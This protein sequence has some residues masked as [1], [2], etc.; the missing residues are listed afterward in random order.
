MT[1]SAG[2]AGGSGAAG[3]AGSNGTDGSGGEGAAAV[4]GSG[5]TTVINDGTLSGGWSADGLR[6][7]NAVEFT[8]G[9]N[10]LELHSNS[11]IE[12][13]AVAVQD[14]ES[15]EDTLALG[16][17][18]DGTFDVGLIGTQYIG[19]TQ[20]DKT[21]ISTW[22]VDGQTTEVAPWTVKE[23]TLILGSTAESDTS[24][25]GDMS[26]DLEGT[27]SG[28]GTVGGN[29]TN[30][31]TISPGA[32]T[33]S[34]GTLT[35]EGDYTQSSDGILE[36]DADQTTGLADKIDV[37][38]TAALDG[39]VHV[40]AQSDTAWYSEHVIVEADEGVT[41]TFD[42]VTDNLTNIDT[43]IT[44]NPNTAVIGL[45]RNDVVFQEEVADL[46]DNQDSTA[47]AID[48]L[49]EGSIYKAIVKDGEGNAAHN[50]DLLSGEI[51]A[52]TASA[53]LTTERVSRGIMSDNMRNRVRDS[54]DQ[55]SSASST[56]A[57][58]YT[59][60]KSPIPDAV[61]SKEPYQSHF[62][63]WGEVVADDLTLK[64]DGNAGKTEQDLAGVFVGGNVMLGG[65]WQAGAAYGHTEAE[66]DVRDRD[67][68][69]DIE[70]NTLGLTVGKSFETGNDNAINFLLGGTYTRSGVE[71]KRDVEIGAIQETLASEYD[72]D[73]VQ[74]FT[75][76][77]Y[78]MRLRNRSILEPYVGL[79]WRSL[80]GDDYQEK[81]GTTALSGEGFELDQIN[82]TVGIRFRQGFDIGSLPAWVQ[83]GAGWEHSFGDTEGVAVHRFDG[84]NEFRVTGA[85]LD[86]DAGILDLS[87]GVHLT[88][89]LSLSTSYIGRFSENNRENTYRLGLNWKF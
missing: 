43:S 72:V 83:V 15:Q 19:F 69:A 58:T 39:S 45:M 17:D 10:L 68:S 30:G 9:G 53:L 16:G 52:D 47:G 88:E 51:H 61:V 38:G 80:S 32:G 75:E 62:A 46:T 18:A 65:G 74:L 87:F 55:G 31:G 50:F 85:P 56:P 60:S 86:R 3:V 71:T 82:T 63:L 11:I 5:N 70:N 48:E 41:G 78:E 57:P 14:D 42:N 64:S 12:G 67:S 76:V 27:L 79:G 73:T 81:G 49:P 20:I 2:T 37:S 25:A 36:V 40:I 33:G 44:Y 35:V 22:T 89:S 7:A 24:I 84:G 77:A 29:L 34:I 23:G 26:V 54:R 21:G 59:D 13:N 28:Y 8:G 4:V 66:V 1:A 6:Q